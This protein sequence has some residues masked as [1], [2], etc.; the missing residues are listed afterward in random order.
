MKCILNG[1]IAVYTQDEFVC[2]KVQHVHYK[3]GTNESLQIRWTTTMIAVEYHKNI[4]IYSG[5]SFVSE[6]AKTAI[7]DGLLSTFRQG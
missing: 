6:M 3:V 4:R 1:Y 5:K 7:K 2:G